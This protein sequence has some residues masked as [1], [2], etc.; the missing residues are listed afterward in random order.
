MAEELDVLD[1]TSGGTDAEEFGKMEKAARA[2]ARGK[3]TFLS[4]LK[5]DGD[6]EILRFLWES[7]VFDVNGNLYVPGAGVDPD[8]ATGWLY[9]KQHVMVKTKDY[10]KDTPDDKKKSWP[11][12]VTAVCRKTPL[13]PNK[14]PAYPECYIDGL[15]NDRGW[16]ERPQLMIWAGAVLREQVVG[17]EEMVEQG[18]IDQSQVGQK[19]ILD[20]QDLIDEVDKD[21][22]ATG[23]KIWKK[24]Y[25]VVNQRVDNFF[26]T[27]VTEGQYRGTI[28]D[29]DYR[30]TRKGAKG[31]KHTFAIN[32]LDPYEV[33]V[34]REGQHVAIKYDVREPEIAALYAESGVDR[35]S[36]AKM[37][38]RR[39]SDAFYHRFFDPRVEVSWNDGRDDDDSKSGPDSPPPPPPVPS[40]AQ[41]EGKSITQE[42]TSGPTAAALDAMRNKVLNGNVTPPPAQNGGGE[43]Q[44]PQETAQQATPPPLGRG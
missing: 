23:R 29:R 26:S 1:F 36:L 8:P 13:G 15:K 19:I 20:Q 31:E 9:V 6:S 7:E 11:E 27:L 39:I 14:R 35:M 10:P 34:E 24:R 25:V 37:V 38:S 44:T 4:T 28:L 21:G 3:S 17:T 32:S 42:P 40:Q 33:T 5:D 30:V 43:Q 16:P 12:K 22:T 41:Q 18:R 2:A